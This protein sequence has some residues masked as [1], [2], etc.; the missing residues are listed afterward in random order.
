MDESPDPIPS[1]TDAAEPFTWKYELRWYYNH[2]DYLHLIWLVLLP[3]PLPFV[4]QHVTL[5]SNTL[6]LTVIFTLVMGISLN[7]GE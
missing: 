4:I 6:Y 7:I 1:F 5:R 2:L 3:I